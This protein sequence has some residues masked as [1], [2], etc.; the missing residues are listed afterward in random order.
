M[1]NRMTNFNVNKYN[2]QITLLNKIVNTLNNTIYSFNSWGYETTPTL[3]KELINNPA[4]MYHKYLSFEYIAQRICAEHEI[5]DKD[6][7]NPHHQDCFCSII[8]EMESIFESFSEFCKLL[9]YI[10]EAYN[11]SLF[12]T[13]KEGRYRDPE[14]VKTKNAEWR[15]M[16]QCVEYE[17][18]DRIN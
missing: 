4:E 6:Y 11:N 16:Q 7:L 3:V 12:Y 14:V 17:D 5:N 15:I 9:P 2:E 1:N 13:E 18:T 10:K 8:D